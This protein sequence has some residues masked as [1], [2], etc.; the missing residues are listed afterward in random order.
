MNL[1]ERLQENF[2]FES[3]DSMLTVKTSMRFNTEGYY[4]MHKF[5]TNFKFNLCGLNLLALEEG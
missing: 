3:T 5:A 4:C 2:F 1:G